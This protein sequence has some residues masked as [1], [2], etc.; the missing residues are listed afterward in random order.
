L[1][2][3]E[4]ALRLL[5][6][7]SEGQ[8]KVFEGLKYSAYHALAFTNNA[9]HKDNGLYYTLGNLPPRAFLLKYGKLDVDN[10]EEFPTFQQDINNIII[11]NKTLVLNVAN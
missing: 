2:I 11:N 10:R 7:R 6:E 8:V 9:I 5:G 1:P 4:Q 3:G